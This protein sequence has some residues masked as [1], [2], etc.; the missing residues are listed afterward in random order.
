MTGKT[1][2]IRWLS[3]SED[4]TT[5]LSTQ[6]HNYVQHSGIF[7][8][9]VDKLLKSKIYSDYIQVCILTVNHYHCE[10]PEY[11]KKYKYL[12]KLNNERP[13]QRNPIYNERFSSLQNLVLIMFK[14]DSV[15]T[16][17]ETSWFGYYPDG[18]FKPVIPPQQTPLYTEDWI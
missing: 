13:N 5:G 2:S 6:A 11:L 9:I 1:D 4:Y 17:K 18:A 14:N 16:P 15:L 7:C 8:Q 3:N 12:P 10:I